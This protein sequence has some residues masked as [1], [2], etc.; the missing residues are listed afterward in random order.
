MV[1]LD[2]VLVAIVKKTE[3]RAMASLR[4]EKTLQRLA[5]VRLVVEFDRRW[6]WAACELEGFGKFDARIASFSERPGHVSANYVQVT[7]HNKAYGRLVDFLEKRG[8]SLKKNAPVVF[9]FT[10]DDKQL[11]DT[12]VKAI[13]ERF[14]ADLFSGKIK[15]K[16]GGVVEHEYVGYIEPSPECEPGCDYSPFTATDMLS[17]YVGA[18][19]QEWRKWNKRAEGEDITSEVIEVVKRAL[20]SKQERGGDEALASK[21]ERGG[22]EE[23]D[24]DV[25]CWEC[26]RRF[27]YEQARRMV[28]RGE[29]TWDGPTGFYCGC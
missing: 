14:L 21:Q 7:H 9:G 23:V 8:L 20:A 27:T 5:G 3:G 6:E 28:A 26:G 25:V 15:V 19:A 13:H 4:I 1:Q 10:D 2:A 24:D 29:A 11:I 18:V 12:Y 22:D 16:T 17:Y